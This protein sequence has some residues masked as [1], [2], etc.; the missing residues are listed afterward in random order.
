ML[1]RSTKP[2]LS[3][4][5]WLIF[6]IATWVPAV[7]WTADLEGQTRYWDE[8]FSGVAVD[9]GV[10]FGANVNLAGQVQL[11]RL[12]C[13]QPIGDAS[14][15]RPL[16]VWAH[17]GGFVAG[18]RS[19]LKAKAMCTA[20][21]KRGYVAA[22]VDYRYGVADTTNPVS[23]ME[24][25]LRTVQDAKA[26]VR[27]FRK[28]ASAYRVDT[29][30]IFFGG[31]SA[32]GVTALLMAYWDQDEIPKGLNPEV[33]GL[34]GNSGNSG[35]ASAVH[36]VLNCWGGIPDTSWIDAGEP[37][38]AGFHGMLDQTVPYDI[39]LSK[40]GFPLYG[41]KAV[42]RIASRLCIYNEL[43]LQP[44]M[45]HGVATQAEMDSLIRFTSRFLFRV[46]QRMEQTG[47][48]GGGTGLTGFRLDQNTPNPFNAST[49][50]RFTVAEAGNVSLNM[51]NAT[52]RKVAVLMNGPV[53]RGTHRLV[54]DGSRLP[55]G[56]YVIVLTVKNTRTAC[57]CLL[58]K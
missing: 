42:C 30:R 38:V 5:T 49:A 26:A 28:N 48:S 23:Y 19:D 11:L 56:V 51:W 17:G 36:A 35:Y 53:E 10:L 4:F 55:G 14:L 50:I 2:S 34:E 32:G 58:V 21:A 20:Y 7:L 33:G 54:F 22:S 12:D 47:V 39:G 37:P 44:S 16:L 18:N 31:S 57:K 8:V 46:M 41:S 24:S 45:K 52:G 13:Y 1:N 27:F 6:F 25:I 40:G 29:T 3:V 15:K 9:S 43:S